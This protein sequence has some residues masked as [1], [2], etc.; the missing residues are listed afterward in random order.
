MVLFSRGSEINF[1]FKFE[2][3][4]KR[5]VDSKI[6]ITNGWNQVTPTLLKENNFCKIA[7]ASPTLLARKKTQHSVTLKKVRVQDAKE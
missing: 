6:K 3:K 7:T 5:N 4:W 2:S 1:N